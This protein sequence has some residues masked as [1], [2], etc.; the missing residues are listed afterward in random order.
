MKHV[1]TS[2]QLIIEVRAGA[3]AR[4]IV[5]NAFDSTPDVFA[6]PRL[7][8][9][10]GSLIREYLSD[11]VELARVA[12]RV[13]D[14]L[15]VDTGSSAQS[16]ISRVATSIR[17]LDDLR[18]PVD[19]SVASRS[20]FSLG[21]LGEQMDILLAWSATVERVGVHRRYAAVSLLS[22]H[23]R[24]LVRAPD[25]HA[26]IVRWIGECARDEAAC[27][28]L[29]VAATVAELARCSLFSYGRYLQSMIAHGQTGAR[30]P[31][32]PASLHQYLL[33]TLPLYAEATT[34]ALQ[35]RV[36]L[37]TSADDIAAA[38]Q[39]VDRAFAAVQAAMPVLVGVVPSLPSPAPSSSVG[40]DQAVEVRASDPSVIAMRSALVEVVSLD[41][42]E[43]LAYG[44]VLPLVVALGGQLDVPSFAIVVDALV[45]LE[46][47]HTLAEVRMVSFGPSADTCCRSS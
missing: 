28:R 29:A 41:E 25:V 11:S 45:T 10:H 20:F 13:D 16:S 6:S 27:D 8:L 14:L 37:R 46:A 42:R 44:R 5:Q 1:S 19:W 26:E 32:R 40:S 33:A 36:T 39:R 22:A 7:W 4:L 47:V 2:L 30:P 31:D 17:V 21:A 34:L 18:H 9:R 24:S 15:G 35:R 3:P 43:Q 38:A 23:L 12:R